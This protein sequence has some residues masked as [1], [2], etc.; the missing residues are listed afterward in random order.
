MKAKFLEAD[1]SVKVLAHKIKTVFSDRFIHIKPEDIYFV[2]KDADKNSWKAKTNVTNGLYRALTGK[3]IIIQIHKQ[4][5][6][7][8]K[9][10][11]KALLLYRELYRI[12]INSKDKSEYKLIREDVKD[13]SKILEK[14]GLHNETAEVFLNKVLE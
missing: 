13:F 8:M 6:N 1:S 5:W 12:D 9:D 11:E 10:T 4:A 14:I 2:F 3:K 7:L